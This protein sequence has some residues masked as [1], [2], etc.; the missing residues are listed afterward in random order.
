MLEMIQERIHS[1]IQNSISHIDTT[2]S[3]IE[4]AIQRIVAEHEAAELLLNAFECTD[5]KAK[6]ALNIILK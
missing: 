6:K 4:A 3:A 2:V 1:Y 5:T